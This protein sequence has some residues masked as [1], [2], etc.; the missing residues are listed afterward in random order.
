MY[1]LNHDH[2]VKLFGVVLDVE[3]SLMLVSVINW[4]RGWN[5][6]FMAYSQVYNN[7]LLNLLYCNIFPG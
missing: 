1:S 4:I 5:L 2:L 3:A 6:I 7:D